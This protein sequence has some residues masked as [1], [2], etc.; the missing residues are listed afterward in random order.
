[1]TP[2]EKA[3][4]NFVNNMDDQR[5]SKDIVHALMS[6]SF[7]MPVNE[8]FRL[9]KL[10]EKVKE[11]YDIYANDRVLFQYW[12]LY[13]NSHYFCPFQRIYREGELILRQL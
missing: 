13:Q 10:A 2:K 6:Y 1:M 4:R 3:I 9:D 11:Y 12:L 7:L 5:T 8:V